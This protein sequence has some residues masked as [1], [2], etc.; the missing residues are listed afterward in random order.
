MSDRSFH[1]AQRMRAGK[2]PNYTQNQTRIVESLKRKSAN[3]RTAIEAAEREFDE[4]DA[5][6]RPSNLPRSRTIPRSTVRSTMS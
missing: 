5:L 3:L 4:P 2:R 1:N 6:L